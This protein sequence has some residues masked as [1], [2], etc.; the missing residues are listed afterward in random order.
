M[1]PKTDVEIIDVDASDLSTLSDAP[2]E[3]GRNGSSSRANGKA[4]PS[5][6]RAKSSARTTTSATNASKRKATVD[7]SGKPVMKK[8]ATGKTATSKAT[9][10]KAAAAKATAS[11]ATS[12]SKAT[13]SRRKDDGEI[14]K[15][16]RK[17]SS[18]SETVTAWKDLYSRPPGNEA[19]PEG[20]LRD[21]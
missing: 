15:V 3:P 10:S 16:I 7:L 5:S 4:G 13:G 1:P 20:E 14:K 21:E 12:T 11:K 8:P 17:R 9:T 2:S 6:A 18:D 19:E